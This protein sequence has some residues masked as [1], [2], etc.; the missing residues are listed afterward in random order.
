MREHSVRTCIA[1]N[2]CCRVASLLVSPVF[3]AST[4]VKH[5]IS[6]LCDGKKPCMCVSMDNVCV[7]WRESTHGNKRIVTNTT[8]NGTK[9]K[10]TLLVR[11]CVLD[12]VVDAN[13][14]R[15]TV[16][17]V[18]SK[19]Y[20]CVDADMKCFKSTALI[21]NNFCFVESYWKSLLLAYP[22]DISM[23]ILVILFDTF[24]FVFVVS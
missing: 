17:L 20:V 7:Y 12:V 21:G 15:F 16:S 18:I 2:C 4:H 10:N 5:W 8:N 24:F 11:F 6:F 13:I 3:F 9:Q 19:Q 1:L 14:L 22:V 23:F